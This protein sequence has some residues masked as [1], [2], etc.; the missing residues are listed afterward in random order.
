[1]KKRIGTLKG[2]PIV[3][4]GG[5]NLI[6]K[7]E[8][9]IND[10]G[11]SSDSSNNNDDISY[12]GL[13][14]AS[15]INVKISSLFPFSK[16]VDFRNSPVN[17]EIPLISGFPDYN[18]FMECGGNI[19]KNVYTNGNWISIKDYLLETIRF[20]IEWLKPISKEDFYRTDYTQEEARKLEQDYYNYT[21][22]FA[23]SETE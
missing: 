14:L 6:K 9:S 3:E 1:M 17:V 4:G 22:Q 16:I 13:G 12:F 18:F 5:S 7:N 23:P 20:N 15:D 11:S 19:N 2:K 21:L 10:I 8:I